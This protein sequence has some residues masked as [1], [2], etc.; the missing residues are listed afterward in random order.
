MTDTITLTG[1][2][3]TDPRHVITNDGLAITSFR[4]ASAQRRFDKSAQKWIDTDTN[5]YSITAFRQLAIN[6]SASLKRGERVVL[7][8]RL[9]IREWDNG[10][11][12]GT[13]IDVEADA[14]GYDM[15]WGSSTFS[16]TVV[17]SPAA[18]PEVPSVDE[19]GPE[20]QVEGSVETGTALE[21]ES[22]PF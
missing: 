2:V 19:F 5:W 3:A 6:T 16:R 10:E 20:P 21:P 22:T 12:K 9:K 11:R 18:S 8:G 17:T 15:T 7:S 14:L 13:A 4:L 1:I